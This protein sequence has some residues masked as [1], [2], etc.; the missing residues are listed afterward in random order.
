MDV[1]FVGGYS[2]H[3]GKRNLLLRRIAELGREYD[4][5]FH[6]SLG[7]AAQLV[8]GSWLM[9]RLVPRLALEGPLRASAR[10]ALYGRAMYELFGNTRIVINAAI[11]M[12]SEFRG[13]MRCWEALGCGAVMLSDEGVYPA[14][15]QAGRDFETYHDADDAFLKIRRILADYEAWRPMAAQG[16]ATVETTYS[17]AAQ[18]GAFVKLVD[19]I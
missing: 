18:W 16:L 19:G 17:K 15:M 10:P 7:R 1:A 8:N 4:I 11:D 9:R 5:R 6:F 3:H 13:N 2:R 14:G 12:A